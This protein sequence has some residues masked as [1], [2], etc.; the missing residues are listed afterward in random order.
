VAPEY[1]VSNDQVADMLRAMVTDSRLTTRAMRAQQKA[2]DNLGQLFDLLSYQK[3]QAILGML[4]RWL[5]ETTFRDGVRRYID[6]HVEG[7][8]T[9]S[10]LWATLSKAAGHDVGAVAGSFLDQAGVPIVTVEPLG[11][12][13]VRLSQRRFV[14]HGSPPLT[15][16]KIPVTLRYAV[17]ERVL[18]QNLLLSEAEQTFE[19]EGGGAPGWIHPN[20]DEL[21]YYRWSVPAPMRDELARGARARLSIRE[22]VGYLGNLRALLIDGQVKSDEYFRA[23]ARF[24]R[25]QDPEVLAA[26]VEGLNASRN[27]FVDARTRPAF[28]AYVRRALGPALERIGL[29][30]R[31][32]EAPRLTLLRPQLM[33]ALAEDGEDP[34]LRRLAR[35][36]VAAWL[37]E[38]AAV[39]PSLQ[40]A[41]LAMAAV[42][43]D[44]L[45]F[46]TYRSRFERA[47]TPTDRA[48]LL[49]AFA[50]F[51][52]PAL[53]RRALDYALTGPLRPQELTTIA[54]TMRE[55]PEL[56]DLVFQWTLDHYD[57]VAKRIPPS[58]VAALPRQAT[59]CSLERVSRAREFFSGSR[60]P[61]GTD[62]ELDRLE[63]TA[64]ECVSLHEREGEAVT[65]AWSQAFAGN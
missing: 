1:H 14:T 11:G 48:R 20:A 40:E 32:G 61:V 50:H 25:D 21:G 55:R 15:V 52:D 54:S 47:Q 16:W 10:D 56:Q 57:A 36:Q 4:E 19:L 43:G 59:G 42:G 29:E 7:N 9:A 31:K 64:Q 23:L 38:P 13:R 49:N 24:A 34:K 5:G 28:A 63:A 39:D 6:A 30:P 12:S 2:S 22:R 45:L 35:D 17:G 65:V 44:S 60:A 8:A 46:G 53:A 37:K 33:L 26:V 3:G 27:P 51:D 58:T 62:K 18:T 41:V